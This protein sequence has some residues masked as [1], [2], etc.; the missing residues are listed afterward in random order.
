MSNEIKTGLADRIQLSLLGWYSRTD[1]P[2]KGYYFKCENNMHGIVHVSPE[3]S[4][5]IMSLRDKI[6]MLCRISRKEVN[7]LKYHRNDKWK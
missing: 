2:T 5:F 7:K 3:N 4:H 6:Q 1:D